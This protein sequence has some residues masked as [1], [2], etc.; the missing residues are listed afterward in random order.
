M[1]TVVIPNWNGGARLMRVLRDLG[2][3]TMRPSRVIVVDNG[4]TDESSDAAEAAGAEVIR[5]GSNRGFAPAV[6]E[7]LRRARTPLV[8][9][10]NNDIELPANWLG[11]MEDGLRRYK[12]ASFATGKIFSAG[13]R[14]RL[15]GTFDLVCRGL[16]AWRAGYGRPDGA[17]W[18]RE[19][20]IASTSLTAAVFKRSVFESVGF[21]DER[22]ESYLEDID[23]S[24]RCAIG[25]IVGVYLPRAVSFHAGSAT[26]GP[27]SPRM[28][29]LIARNHGVLATKYG[30]SRK[31][32]VARLLWGGL[33]LR[34]GAFFAWLR[35]FRQSNGVAEP[36]VLTE[37][38]QARLRAALGRQEKELGELQ[39]ATGSDT[40]WKLYFLLS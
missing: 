35:G 22:F 17:A 15:D 7:G 10:L 24:I 1:T 40:Y 6:N 28:V 13:Q 12:D 18:N 11:Q 25:G 27:W 19:R 21:L 34:H 9:I 39:R 32:L 14:D 30:T 23:L 20:Y 29:G 38:E 3:Q 5:F 4:S 16:A 33:A 37:D 26:L 8:A 31:T 2:A 36:V